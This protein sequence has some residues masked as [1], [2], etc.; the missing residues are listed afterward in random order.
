MLNPDEHSTIPVS[1]PPR[2]GDVDSSSQMCF[3]CPWSELCIVS[4][5]KK[6]FVLI[7]LT[8]KLSY[9]L[10]GQLFISG[11]MSL[12]EMFENASAENLPEVFGQVRHRTCSPNQAFNVALFPFL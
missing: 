10:F 1:I 2:K 12:W 7:I 6:T 3:F 8:L 9:S 4:H 5:L 11:N